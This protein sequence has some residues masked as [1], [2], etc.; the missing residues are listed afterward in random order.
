MTKTSRK[1]SATD[2]VIAL[3]PKRQK[4]VRAKAR[5]GQGH[6]Y[7]RGNLYWVKLHVPGVEKPIFQSS[8]DLARGRDGTLEAHAA[9]LLNELQGKKVRNELPQQKALLRTG[10]KSPGEITIDMVMEHYFEY[11][12]GKREAEKRSR[13]IS[14][15]RCHVRRLLE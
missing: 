12:E 7:K 13:D 8:K 1:T 5:N 6:I 14:G 9:A 4:K 15:V 11:L 3:V 10:A 2:N